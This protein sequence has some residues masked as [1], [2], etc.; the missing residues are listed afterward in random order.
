[1]GK[2]KYKNPPINE[3]SVSIKKISEISQLEAIYSFHNP[4]EIKRFLSSYDFIIEYLFEAHDQIRRFFGEH[5]IEILLEYDKDPN[6]NFKG[7]FVVIKTNLSPA[8]SLDLLEKFDE[9][10]W[11]GVDFKIRSLISITVR[12]I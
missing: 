6:E 2:K 11:L 1:M 5:I 8:E 9:E 7:L 10:W 12:A 4:D 3:N